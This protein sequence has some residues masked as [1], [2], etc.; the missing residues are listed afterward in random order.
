MRL[1]SLG[2]LRASA[3]SIRPLPENLRTGSPVD[4]V[5]HERSN[6]FGRS[7]HAIA[8][9]PELLL[10]AP[11]PERP[12]L[13]QPELICEVTRQQSRGHPDPMGTHEQQPPG[14]AYSPRGL[15]WVWREKS[16][17]HRS[18]H[19]PLTQ[20]TPAAT[21]RSRRFSLRHRC[22]KQTTREAQPVRRRLL[23][24]QPASPFPEGI[25]ESR[26]DS[27]KVPQ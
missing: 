16:V 17:R 7:C 13:S 6:R 27:G 24:I 1:R 23:E 10:D 19:D 25:P 18:A 20:P 22:S 4:K 3:M 12:N 14:G 8:R 5:D 11:V 15:V 21:L 9:D 2:L 26:L